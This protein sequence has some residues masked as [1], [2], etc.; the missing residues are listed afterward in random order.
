MPPKMLSPVPPESITDGL[1][2]DAMDIFLYLLDRFSKKMT[3]HGRVGAVL[4]ES[5]DRYAVLVRKDQAAAG[6]EGI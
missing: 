3:V 2:Q 5:A 1:L 6:T 4:Q